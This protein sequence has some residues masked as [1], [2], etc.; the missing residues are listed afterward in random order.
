MQF[1]HGWGAMWFLWLSEEEE[2]RTW[3]DLSGWTNGS[4]TSTSS[5][6]ALRDRAEG[7]FF[8]HHGRDRHP[9]YQG[10]GGVWA[11]H[12]GGGWESGRPWVSEG[13]QRE[14]AAGLWHFVGWWLDHIIRTT[15]DLVVSFSSRMFTDRMPCWI[16]CCTAA[17]VKLAGDVLQRSDGQLEVLRAREGR[18]DE[19]LHGPRAHD[20]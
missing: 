4:I 17:V 9:V 11:K 8:P 16:G 14:I 5:L 10:M 19:S 15:S 1:C 6:A 3:Q 7:P 2:D 13:Y 18:P 20:L 12:P